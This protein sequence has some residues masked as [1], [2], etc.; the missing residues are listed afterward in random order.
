MILYDVML[1]SLI[2][3]NVMTV[4]VFLYSY[5]ISKSKF[6]MADGQP[7]GSIDTGQHCM[8]HFVKET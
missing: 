2:M 4:Y 7:Y 6:I 5:G 3:Q 8:F 1:T